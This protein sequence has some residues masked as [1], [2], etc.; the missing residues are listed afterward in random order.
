MVVR[1]RCSAHIALHVLIHLAGTEMNLKTNA[2]IRLV[3]LSP[4]F[5]TSSPLHD[6]LVEIA[7]KCR[8]KKE[9]C[10]LCHE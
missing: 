5:F 4:N 10:V 7:Y 3:S 6:G 8:K 9:Y 1:Y 2:F